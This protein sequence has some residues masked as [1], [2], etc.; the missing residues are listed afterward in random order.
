MSVKNTILRISAAMLGFSCVVVQIIYLR[1][2]FNIFRGNELVIGIVLA[3]WMAETGLGALTGRYLRKKAVSL[4]PFAQIF[5]GAMP[6]LS[7]VGV[8]LSRNLIFTPGVMLGFYDILITTLI[9]LLPFTFVSGALF[10]LYCGISQETGIKRPVAGIYAYES[11]GGVAGGI[12]FYI[13]IL[14]SLEDYDQLKAVFFLN[15]TVSLLWSMYISSGRKHLIFIIVA[16]FLLGTVI[17]KGGLEPRARK[18]ISGGQD[19]LF[20]TETP[21]GN[22]T[23]TESAGQKNFL[24][25]GIPIFSSDNT[26]QKEEMVHYALTQPLQT[27]SILL[28]GGGAEGILYEC[29]KYRPRTI[30]LIE[31]NKDLIRAAAKYTGNLPEDPRIHIYHRDARN[32][33]RKTRQKY[34]AVLVN[35]P[36]PVNM[37][38]NRFYTIDFIRDCREKMNPGGVFSISI[39]SSTGY[40]GEESAGIHSVLFTTLKEIFSNVIIIPGM[41][42]YFLASDSSL[43]FN[44][45][46]SIAKKGID[47]DYVNWYY[48]DDQNLERNSRIIMDRLETATRVNT[49]FK[50]YFYYQ[51][52]LYWISISGDKV[53]LLLIFVSLILLTPLA[54]RK[55]KFEKGI[56]ITGF[57]ATAHEIAV[58]M[59]FQAIF[60]Y[61]YIMSGVFI[62]IFMAGLFIGSYFPVKRAYGSPRSYSILQT[63]PGIIFIM[64]WALFAVSGNKF[65][66]E[67]LIIGLLC[68]LL[69]AMAISTGLL[70]AAGSHFSDRETTTKASGLY[71]SDLAGSALGALLVSVILLPMAGFFY[72]C[73]G[74]A[75]LNFVASVYLYRKNQPKK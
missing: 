53:V 48:I 9:M 33:L 27:E 68:L 21:Y 24:S 15:L 1:K 46:G 31:Q 17:I 67:W 39:S 12:F 58:M 41:K 71:S 44:I 63:L 29:L 52:V 55:N 66:A 26:I 45:T 38:L 32:F 35:V 57:T 28:V 69:L 60:G 23:V 3:S 65:I 64:T 49:D 42:S 25:D 73:A 7:V 34:D 30:D 47:T 74:T 43:T 10:T 75:I 70:F 4:A 14:L 19:I 6:F 5:T 54:I 18:A 11:A 22:L 51:Q 13:A 62:T 59:A 2:L 50:P 56:Y 40:L 37:Q 16:A 72:L 36:D 20:S 8:I 61:V